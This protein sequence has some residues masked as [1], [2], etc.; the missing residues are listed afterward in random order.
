MRAEKLEIGKIVAIHALKGEMRVQPWC[1]TPEFLCRF[2][3]LFLDGEEYRVQS[4]RPHKN[5]MILKLR[6]IET[7]EAAQKLVN[8]ILFAAREDF[9]L[10]KGT[11]LIADLIGLKVVDADDESLVY[12]ELTDVSQTGANDVYHIRFADGK[13]RYIPAIPQV[14]RET[15]P[16]A[17][18]MKI[19]PLD[20]LFDD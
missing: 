8:K 4:A 14:V 11:Y 15:D 3:R 5:V 7:P 1:D 20:G 18:I 6:G 10:D 13:T 9:K 2:K 19:K 12:G 16:E 17:G